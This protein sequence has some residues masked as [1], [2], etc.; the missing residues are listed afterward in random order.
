[1]RVDDAMRPLSQCRTA[2]P[3]ETVRTVF[4]HPLPSRRTGAV[5]INDD[6]GMLAGIFTDSDLARLFERRNDVAIDGPI[7]GVMTSLPTTVTAGTRLRDAVAVLESRR[8]SEL[9]VVDADGRPLGLLDIVD[10]VGLVPA[11]PV[12]ATASDTVPLPGAT[13]A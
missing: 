6:A 3:E 2:R 12:T 8:L 11:E 13:A 4:S 7:R 10:L 1:M 5:M 9:P